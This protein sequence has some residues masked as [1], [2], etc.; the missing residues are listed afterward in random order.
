MSPKQ[1]SIDDIVRF[2]SGSRHF[3]ADVLRVI[4]QL[5][6]SWGCEDSRREAQLII[7]DVGNSHPGK[8]PELPDEIGPLASEQG[9]HLRELLLFRRNGVPIQCRLGYTYS[10]G[11]YLHVTPDVLV[12]SLEVD[13]LID[14][15]GVILSNLPFSNVRVLDVGTGCGVIAIALAKQFAHSHVFA[16]D[17]SEKALLVARANAALNRV[18]NALFICGDMFSALRGNSSRQSDLLVSN[19]PYFTTNGL[20]LLPSALKRYVPQ[21]AINGGSDGLSFFRT[22]ALETHCHI[23]IG[24]YAIFLHAAG[25]HDKVR[26][27]FDVTGRYEL[28]GYRSDQFRDKRVIILRRSR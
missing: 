12:P 22:L 25:Q 9:R 2:T 28:V 8:V 16:T 23:G 21:L 6:D 7:A 14:S 1:T 18:C 15:A 11:C 13:A 17:V 24:G 4:T 3:A 20:T 27:L 19:P 10:H 5:L 26:S